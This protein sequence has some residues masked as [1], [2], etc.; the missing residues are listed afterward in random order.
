MSN[1]NLGGLCEEKGE[2]N[3][4]R[5]SLKFHD[6]ISGVCL[7]M[8]VLLFYSSSVIKRNKVILYLVSVL[9]YFF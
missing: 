7:C 5:L 2:Q 8:S 6:S 9:K 1:N 4:N 3:K